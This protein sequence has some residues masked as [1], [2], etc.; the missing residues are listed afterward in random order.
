M[1]RKIILR[2]LIIIIGVVA[3]I[4]PLLVATV[5]AQTKAIPKKEHNRLDQLKRST[6]IQ[7]QPFIL[8]YSIQEAS[9]HVRLNPRLWNALSPSEQRQICDTLAATDVWKT[10]G[11]LNAYLYVNQTHIGRIGPNWS[12]GFEFKPKLRSLE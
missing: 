11:L 3:I 8:S 9:A 7:G 10:M 5:Q 1:H 4:G 2:L 6:T 12:G